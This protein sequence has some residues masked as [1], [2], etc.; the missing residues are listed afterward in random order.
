[1]TERFPPVIDGFMFLRVVLPQTRV[2]TA[3]KTFLTNFESG[4]F[5]TFQ[6]KKSLISDYVAAR[7][8]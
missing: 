7:G 6:R 8:S 2:T 5:I 4:R 3:L 1:M